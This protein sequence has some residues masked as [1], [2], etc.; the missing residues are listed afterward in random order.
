[1]M[2]KLACVLLLSFFSLVAVDGENVTSS[3]KQFYAQLD[4]SKVCADVLNRYLLSSASH[5]GN[6]N[7]KTPE[8]D[9]RAYNPLLLLQMDYDRSKKIVPNASIYDVL[10][11]DTLNFEIAFLDKDG[12]LVATLRSPNNTSS[13]FELNLTSSGGQP[14]F[15]TN[16][17]YP[18]DTLTTKNINDRAISIRD[19]LRLQPDVILTYNQLAQ[20]FLFL[21]ANKIY[22][23]RIQFHDSFE[24]DRYVDIV[25]RGKK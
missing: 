9:L 6:S 1:M 22:V 15:I 19:I 2:N 10:S 23:Y 13:A 8:L 3:I 17:T 4:K 5:S 21:K 7:P 14:T 24:L 12:L 11:L 16:S 20:T 25:I 18:K